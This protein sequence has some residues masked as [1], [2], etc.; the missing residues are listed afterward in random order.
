MT[1]CLLTTKYKMAYIYVSDEFI[2]TNGGDSFKSDEGANINTVLAK[3][4]TK[5]YS[6]S[7]KLIKE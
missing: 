2:V 4:S 7:L 3:Y 5:N 6:P 1:K